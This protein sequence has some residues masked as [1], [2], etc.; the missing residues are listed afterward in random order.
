MV[1]FS[2]GHFFQTPVFEHLYQNPGFKIGSGTGNQGLV[3][4]ADLAPEMT[5]SGELGVQQQL[6]DDIAIDVTGYM[7]DIRNLT[8]TRN[9]EIVVFGGSATYSK[10]V[11]SDFGFVKGIVLTLNKRFAGGLAATVDYTFQVARGSASDPND[12]RNAILG[13][14]QPE[15]QMNPLSWDQRH[16]VNVTL[17]YSKPTWGASSVI[18]YGSGFPY[19]PRAT[20]D[21]TALLTNSQLKPSFF[22]IDVQGFYVLPVSEIKIIAFLRI[23]NILDIR[24]ETNVFVD[25]GRAGF[26]TDENVALATNPKQYVNSVDQWFRIPTHYSEPRRIE[27]GFNMEF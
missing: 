14:S 27:F 5:V 1:H 4:N 3:G 10:Y 7:R 20:T 11:N 16:T 12:A 8:G 2:Y 21:I 23:F 15:V 9:A 22:D 26:T 24:N 19:T 25:T 6:S 18:Q 17:N 13:G